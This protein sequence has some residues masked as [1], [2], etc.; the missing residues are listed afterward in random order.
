MGGKGSGSKQ[1]PGRCNWKDAV[2]QR[3]HM[4]KMSAIGLAARAQKLGPERVAEIARY[5][6]SFRKLGHPA[7][8]KL[9]RREARCGHG[10]PQSKTRPDCRDCSRLKKYGLTRESHATLLLKQG[11]VCAICENPETAL[12]N[13]G[14][15]KPLAVDHDH[16]SGLVRGLL[17]QSCN[18]AIGLMNHSIER[19][20]SAAR[21]LKGE[22]RCLKEA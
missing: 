9:D 19:L 4:A 12:G 13:T 5:A 2:A 22:L 8:N 3:E 20:S 10:A 14:K 6:H 1:T 7:P 16:D 18:I 17:C 15:T 11:S 21:Y